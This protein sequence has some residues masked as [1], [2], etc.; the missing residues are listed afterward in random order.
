MTAGQDIAVVAL[1]GS[2][3]VSQYSVHT[4]VSE[5]ILPYAFLVKCIPL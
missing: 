3:N 5:E 1:D 2:D 4:V